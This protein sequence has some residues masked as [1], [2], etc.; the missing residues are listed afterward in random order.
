[1]ST[2][3]TYLHIVMPW[4]RPFSGGL[5]HAKK[6]RLFRR[7]LKDSAVPGRQ[8]DCRPDAP[9]RESRSAP[10]ASNFTIRGYV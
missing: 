8:G 3:R 9:G 10:T 5:S 1:M 4:N 7:W 6:K 2:R